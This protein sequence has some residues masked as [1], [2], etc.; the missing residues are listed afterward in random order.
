MTDFGLARLMADYESRITREGETFGT[1]PYMSPEQ[2]RGKDLDPRSDMYSVGI[3]LYR[4]LTGRAPFTGD[5]PGIVIHQSLNEP[6][7]S[8]R[9]LNPG[10][11]QDVIRI[12]NKSTAKSPEKRYASALDM[13]NVIQGHL[14]GM[15]DTIVLKDLVLKWR[16]KYLKSK[17]IIAAVIVLL[18]I[19]AVVSVR[20]RLTHPREVVSERATDRSPKEVA[21][22]PAALHYPAAILESEPIFP[23]IS[24][25]YV[26]MGLADGIVALDDDTLIVVQEA[27]MANGTGLLKCERD[28]AYSKDDVFSTLGPPYRNPDGLARLPDGGSAL[29]DGQ[30][31]AVFTVPPEG[32]PPTILMKDV[33]VYTNPAV[34]PPGF[35]GPNVN[36][37]DVLI[38]YW[39]P[40]QIVAFDIAT[41]T[42]KVFVDPSFFAP[43]TQ[44]VGAL[45]FGPDGKLYAAWSDYWGERASPRIYRFGP[46][47]N[48][49]VF[50]ELD[51]LDYSRVLDV[52]IAID[53]NS[54]WLY[55]GIV[56][57][58]PGPTSGMTLIFRA[59]L[60]GKKIEFAAD[61]G[62]FCQNLELSPD[63]NR[64]YIGFYGGILEASKPRPPPNGHHCRFKS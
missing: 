12:L 2:C 53:H 14:M 21:T 3:V 29:T 20:N 7:P 27:P 35:D 4:M 58:D 1:P 8:A 10:L 30:A 37:G 32:G 40:A 24:N 45:E 22:A 28:G 47:G 49:E 63:G 19:I 48:G 62:I 36:P 6:L 5:T 64:I 56:P 51:G 50:L 41:S 13:K 16:R 59:S 61:A 44:G 60:D 31:R 17:S 43:A 34:A 23:I 54:G 9:S 42:S 15:G 57:L 18:A 46:D 26:G 38:P 25:F 52:K 33:E 39:K 55:Y 11:P